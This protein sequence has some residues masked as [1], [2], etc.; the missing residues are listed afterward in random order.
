MDRLRPQSIRILTIAQF[1]VLGLGLLIDRELLRSIEMFALMP[2]AG[3]AIYLARS[4]SYP[5]FLSCIAWNVHHYY[6]AWVGSPELLHPAI[7]SVLQFINALTTTYYLLPWVRRTYLTPEQSRWW[8][9]SSRYPVRLKATMIHDQRKSKASLHNLSLGG[10][11]IQ[12]NEDLQ[13]DDKVELRF[14]VL[15]KDYVLRGQVVYCVKGSL[16]GYG[17]RFEHNEHTEEDLFRLCHC[18][19]IL[20]VEPE[21]YDSTSS[22]APKPKRWAA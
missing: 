22:S 10:A 16:Q 12:T 5:I 15:T 3:L 7:W 4:W 18:L 17:V 8:K 21:R 9:T 1:L 20:K 14:S 6:Q 2:L 13:A 11:L 19:E